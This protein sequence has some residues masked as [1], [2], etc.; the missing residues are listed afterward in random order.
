[1]QLRSTRTRLST[2]VLAVLAVTALGAGTLTSAP[3]TFAAPGASPRTPSAPRSSVLPVFPPDVQIAQA[4]VG[5]FFGYSF[6]PDGERELRWWPYGGGAPTLLDYPRGGGWA[7]SG[8]DVVA[9]GDD[10]WSAQMRSLTLRNMADPFAPGVDIDLGALGGNYVAVLSP[11]SVLAQLTAEDGTAELHIVSKDGAETS[12]RKIAGLPSDATDFTGS[13]VQGG[14][15]LV[16]YETG[17]ANARTGGRALID[18]A[19]ARASESYASADSGYDFS[20]LMFS[21]THVAWLDYKSG[22]GMYV[23]SVDR[24]T[25][26][27]KRTVLGAR[28]GE[29]YTELV[30]GWLVYGRPSSPVRAVSLGDGE[31]VELAESGSGSAMA[32][33]GSALVTGTRAVDGEGLFRIRAGDDGRPTVTKVADVGTPAG[34]EIQQAHVPAVADLD[35]TGGQVNLGWT[36]SRADARLDLTLTHVGTGKELRTRVNAPATGTRFSY[37]WDGTIAGVDAP[38]GAYTVTAVAASLDGTGEPA[39]Q[40]TGMTV[41][42]T[43]NPHDYTD[44]GSTDLL[45]RDAS[46]VLWRDDLQDRPL[47]GQVKPVQRSRVGGGWQTYKQ[48][49]AVGDL[50]GSSDGDLVALDSSG[51]LWHYLGKGDGTFATRARV[52]GGWNVYDKLTGGSD[53]DGDGR[54]DLLAA[55]TTG[56]LWFYKGTGSTAAPFAARVRVGG[57][58]GVYNQITAV[59]DNAGTAA[60]DL[61]A[62]DKDGVLWLYQGKGGGQFSSRVRVGGGWGVYT[63]L[64]GAGDVD[65][66][67]IPDLIAYGAGGTYLY[68]STGSSTAVFIRRTT[69]VYGGEGSK[70][71]NIA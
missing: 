21:G 29:W 6:T 62:R 44:N 32:E 67:G 12:S 30:G 53:L 56:V 43:A 55:D 60:G 61:V 25:G 9:L 51:V 58:W 5:G 35:R 59:G 24:V 1:M 37:V 65:S 66:D 64:V 4:G 39:L 34:V 69:S 47:D 15:V 49:E 10:N 18:L 33:D 28:D 22:T 20:H 52:G 68:H 41:E 57:G 13:S 40:R 70:F 42:R 19:D 7:T 26:E 36:L 23:T 46:G 48:I 45:A 31:E 16:G 54:T 27:E 17:P 11:T 63:H 50:A 38:N 14:V 8:G 71:N 3:A 2:A